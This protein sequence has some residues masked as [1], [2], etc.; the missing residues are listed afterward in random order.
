MRQCLQSPKS[1]CRP[2]RGWRRP[3]LH[4]AAP[5]Q[6]RHASRRTSSPTRS[7]ARHGGWWP[8]SNRP[9]RAWPGPH[10]PGRHRPSEPSERRPVRRLDFRADTLRIVRQFRDTTS[11]VLI[12]ST[13]WP[14]VK[15]VDLRAKARRGVGKLC[16]SQVEQ[17][18]FRVQNAVQVTLRLAPPSAR[19]SPARSDLIRLV[20]RPCAGRGLVPHDGLSRASWTT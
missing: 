19:Q 9:A 18:Q 17:F 3:T 14:P 10:P 2:G 13:G 4:K 5:R 15:I 11:K 7:A 1:R 6:C 16:Q 8:A 20:H 12:A